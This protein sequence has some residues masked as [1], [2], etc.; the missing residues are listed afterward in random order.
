MFQSNAQD[1]EGLII[2]PLATIMRLS[3]RVPCTHGSGVPR[4]R[5]STGLLKWDVRTLRILRMCPVSSDRVP[6]RLLVRDDHLF[7][8]SGSE[9]PL[10]HRR[11]LGQSHHSPSHP[12]LALGTELR[13]GQTTT[14]PASLATIA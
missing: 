4:G 10:R 14:H 3:A 12:L 11:W 9:A 6:L 1:T 5:R 2:G 8:A 7:G 13:P